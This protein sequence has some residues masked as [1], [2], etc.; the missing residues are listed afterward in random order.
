MYVV[1]I[2]VLYLQCLVTVKYM[3]VIIYIHTYSMSTYI[4]I[5]HIH[6]HTHIHIYVHTYMYCMYS[7]SVCVCVY[8]YTHTHTHTL[9][10]CTIHT[11]THYQILNS[12]LCKIWQ[13]LFW[14]KLFHIQPFPC[15][16]G[17]CNPVR[18]HGM[19]INYMICQL[20]DV[21]FVKN[22]YVCVCMTCTRPLWT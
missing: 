8:I 14:F 3:Y 21:G 12:T 4:H 18:I 17:F 6:T 9:S 1:N 11:H 10:L 5:A 13:N 7:V 19:K 16:H 15:P 20:T 2:Y 22:I